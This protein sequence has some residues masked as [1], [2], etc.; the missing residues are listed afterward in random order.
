MPEPTCETC[1]FWEHLADD[2]NGDPRDALGQ[3]RRYPPQ[4]SVWREPCDQLDPEWLAVEYAQ[5]HSHAYQWCGEHQ[6]RESSPNP[7]SPAAPT[8]CDGGA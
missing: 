5:P 4:C 2:P 1:R 8:E 7:P 3:C 6:P